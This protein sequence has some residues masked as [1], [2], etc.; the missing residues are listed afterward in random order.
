M[1][2]RPIWQCVCLLLLTGSAGCLASGA[3]RADL[4]PLPR[5]VSNNAVAVL[6]SVRG[7]VLYS[8]S[9][10]TA[11]K[12]HEDVTDLA[13]RLPAGSAQWEALPP[14]PGPPRLASVAAVAGN[15]IYLF[16]GYTVAADGGEV[17]VPAVLHFDPEARRYT[18]R[19]P[20]PVPVDDAVALTW[21]DRF[22]YLVSGWHDT[23]NVNLVQRYD[24]R[25]DEWTQA[26][27]FPGVPVFGHAGG[28]VGNDLLVCDGVRIVTTTAQR[29]FA[30]EPACYRGRIR[31]DEPRRIDWTLADHHP[32]PARYRMAATGATG[33]V[34]FV[35]GSDNPYNYNG[36][37]YNGEPSEPLATALFYSFANG[38]WRQWQHAAGASMDHRGLLPLGDDSYAIVGG[39]DSGQRVNGKVRVLA[40]PGTP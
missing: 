35:G 18:P 8:F 20:M 33:G 1:Y 21:R 5:P 16:G 36:I 6:D 22:V 29:D 38:E 37:G 31:E 3:P 13:F 4:P 12:S 32:G 25:N 7:P 17:S 34:L 2:V 19:A 10:L 28:I 24:T 39:M 40:V 26:T 27:P 15:A 30:N 9:G 14:V 11:G 23:G